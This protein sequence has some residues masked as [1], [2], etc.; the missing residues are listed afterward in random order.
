[1]LIN[2][3]VYEEGRELLGPHTWPEALDSAMGANRFGWI[4]LHNASTEEIDAVSHRLELHDLVVEDIKVGQQMPKLEEYPNYIFIVCKQA[5][6]SKEGGLE[7]GDVS[8]VVNKKHVVTFR[9]GAGEGFTSVRQRARLEPDL[10]NLGAGYV[11]YAVLDTVVDRYFPI[12]KNLEAEFERLED[13]VFGEDGT[14]DAM[15]DV[16][17]E[18]LTRSLY[19]LRREVGRF[20]GLVEPLL[21]VT[22]KLFGGRVPALCDGLG[23]YFRDIHDHLVRIVARLDSLYATMGSA[24]QAQLSLTTIEEGKVTKRLAAYASIFAADTLW[25][26]LW[27]MNFKHMPELDWKYGYPLALLI[28]TITSLILFRQFR[29]RR[30][31]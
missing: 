16:P 8:F 12:V 26:G 10:L 11:L 19:H 25:V 20:R 17:R 7:E 23:E 22:I 28:I 14:T 27:G 13:K 24:L 3:S 6:W 21:E 4:G 15:L 29:K 2:A 9:R 5:K 1:M 18:Q 31:L 30:W